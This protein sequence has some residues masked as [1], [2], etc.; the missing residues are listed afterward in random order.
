MVVFKGYPLRYYYL[1]INKRLDVDSSPPTIRN[2]AD[3]ELSVIIGLSHLLLIATYDSSEKLK[4]R[5]KVGYAASIPDGIRVIHHC[6]SLVPFVV[7]FFSI[8]L[9]CK[10]ST[11]KSF[12]FCFRFFIFLFFRRV[13]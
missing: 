6:H 13:L 12:S 10:I 2:D 4:P 5:T 7:S 8:C 3:V 9:H 11:N 1:S